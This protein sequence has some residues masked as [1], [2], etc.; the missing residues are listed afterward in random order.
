MAVG[1]ELSETLISS[2]LFLA[3]NLEQ[4]PLPSTETS[5]NRDLTMSNLI[6]KPLLLH[7][8]ILFHKS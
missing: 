7:F 4:V 1:V 8:T 5:E 2:S 3:P 6:P